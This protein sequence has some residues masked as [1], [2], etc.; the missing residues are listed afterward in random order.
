[1]I[2]TKFTFFFDS[3]N[4]GTPKLSM[5]SLERSYVMRIM[6]AKRISVGLWG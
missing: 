5:F 3:S 1:M 2:P 6:H 4:I